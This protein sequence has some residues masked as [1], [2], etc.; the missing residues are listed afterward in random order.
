M[1][2]VDTALRARE[3]E[4]RPIRVALVG[5]GFMA[6]GLA[7]QICNHLPGLRLVAVVNRTLEQ[8]RTVY[9]QAG[10]SS[11][12]IV[13]VATAAE[14]ESAIHA[15][16]PTITTQVELVCASDQV[17]V[18]LEATGHIAHAAAVAL[19]SF[20]HGKPFVTMTAE[21]DATVGPILRRKADE[22]GVMYCVADGDQ[23][24]VEM[25]LYR[26]VRAYGL[27]PLVCGN[28]K[29]FL[30]RHHTP[31]DVRPF[32]ERTGQSVNM[33]CGFA[34]G[35]KVNIEQAVVANAT[36][37]TIARRGMSARPFAG[38]IDELV[39]HYD[40]ADLRRLGGVV[41]Y[42]VGAKPTPGVFVL[43][44]CDDPRQLVYLDVYKLGRGPLFNFYTPYHLCHLE[45]P[46]SVA[47][48]V[49]FND[50][51]IRPRAGVT[52]Q[53]EVV[54]VAK[55]DLRAGSVLDGIGGYTLYGECETT[56]VT[57]SER[58]LPI[59]VAEGCRVIRDVPRDQVLTYADVEVPANR[60]IDRLRSEQASLPSLATSSRH[61][62]H[63]E[64]TQTPAPMQRVTPPVVVPVS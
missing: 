45:A 30:S 62:S 52:P 27:T 56:A 40:V 13:A 61:G 11:A 16:T 64:L 8:A 12:T 1:I 18:I 36:G 41:D 38:H 21:V 50:A 22:A 34:D 31:D 32:A 54:A 55:T 44:A 19:S 17:D 42:I 47:R 14:L 25:N 35:T 59:G 49:L 20:A 53:V 2:L 43:A 63:T 33:V 24:A 29:G 46:L 39:N 48:A 7:N 51:P 23:P 3:A 6:R 57:S 4:G 15:H 37:M 58:L 10:A 9:A 60:L 28:V 5:A 26:A